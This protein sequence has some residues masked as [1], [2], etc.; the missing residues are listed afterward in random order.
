MKDGRIPK[1]ILFSDLASRK[2]SRERPQFRYKDVFKRDLKALDI[3]TKSWEELAVDKKNGKNA[4]LTGLAARKRNMRYH[5]EEKRQERKRRNMQPI[6]SITF[7]CQSCDRVCY[8]QIG[9]FSQN[10]HC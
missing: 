3:D 6:S 9:L 2:R 7:K 4:L 5:K 1:D 10:R 8:S